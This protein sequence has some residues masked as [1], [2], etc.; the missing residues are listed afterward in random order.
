MGRGG[1]PI[2]PEPWETY[3]NHSSFVVYNEPLEEDRK[4]N[5]LVED[6]EGA[7]SKVQKPRVIYPSVLER[8]IEPTAR[9]FGV[10]RQSAQW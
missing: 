1:P 9:Y 2:Y 7:T 10:S 3:N 6:R 5:L 4:Q 8:L